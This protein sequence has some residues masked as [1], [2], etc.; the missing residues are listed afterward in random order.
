[1]SQYGALGHVKNQ[2]WN[3]E[4]ILKHYYPGI[5]INKI[6]NG[7][8][9]VNG[10]NSYGQSFNNE[11]YPLEEYLKH[12]YEV[13]SSWPTEILKAQA[14]AA[15]SYAYGKS[16]ICPGK[17]S[18]SNVKTQTAWK[19]AVKDIEGIMTGGPGNCGI[20]QQLAVGLMVWVG[21]P[22]MAKEDQL[23]DNH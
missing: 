6:D 1:M 23:I 22:Q 15:R 2:S 18:S 17:V 3:Y 21:I 4:Q 20:L 14:I 7:N 5:S 19:Q 13:P 16:T 10:T 8:I 12:I 11:S 9:T